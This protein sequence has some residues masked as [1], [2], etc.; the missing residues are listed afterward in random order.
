MSIFEYRKPLS[1]E[2]HR[3]QLVTLQETLKSLESEPEE[4]ARTADLK[5]ILANR[6]AELERKTA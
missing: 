2:P 5:R 3:S 6:I 4:T 1:E